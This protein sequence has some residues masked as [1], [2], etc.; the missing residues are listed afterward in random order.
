[1][2]RWLL[3]LEKQV[4]PYHKCHFCN[5]DIDDLIRRWNFLQAGV[6]KIMTNLKDGVDMTT[7]SNMLS[8]QSTLR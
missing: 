2:E 8:P 6:D 7:V 5:I 3:E 4:Q 1:M